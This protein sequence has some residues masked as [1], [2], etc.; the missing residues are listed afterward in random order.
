M[1]GRKSKSGGHKGKSRGWKNRITLLLVIYFAG[2]A[3][4]I[5]CLAPVPEARAAESGKKNF[6][7]SVLKSDK[8]AQ[9]FN[10]GMH[11]CLKLAKDTFTRA[12]SYLKSKSDDKDQNDN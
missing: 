4:A 2:F 8:F 7:F 6:S 9:S 10:Q 12:N 3:S 1:G 5:Y 11:K